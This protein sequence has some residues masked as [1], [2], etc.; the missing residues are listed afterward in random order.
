MLSMVIVSVSGI[1]A[2]LY[3]YSFDRYSLLYY[4]DSISHLVAARK[5]VDWANPSIYQIGTVW[6][7]LLH[8]FLIPFTL[9]DFLFTNG[10]AGTI[11]SLSALSIATLYMVKIVSRSQGSERIAILS[12]L[13]FSS[14]PSI[15]YMGVIAM[16]ESIFLAFF[17]SSVYYA[18]VWHSEYG[19]NSKS[20][21]TLSACLPLIVLAT[22]TRYEGWLLPVILSILVVSRIRSFKDRRGRI[23]LLLLALASF[24]GIFFWLLWNSLAFGDPLA[25][26]NTPLY[27]YLAQATSRPFREFLFL[28]PLSS[29]QTLISAMEV[30]YGAPLLVCSFIGLVSFVIRGNGFGRLILIMLLTLPTLATY[31]A[32]VLG[33]GEVFDQG[34]G[35]WFNSRFVVL[36]SGAITF[37]GISFLGLTKRRTLVIVLVLILASSAVFASVRQLGYPNTPM[38]MK[39]AYAGFTYRNETLSAIETAKALRENYEGGT[40]LM[41]TSSGDAHK[42]MLSSGI[43]LKNF[44]D[45]FSE[46]SWPIVEDSRIFNEWVIV[47][48]QPAGDAVQAVRFLQGK[49]TLLNEKY[50]IVG[51]N[52]F[53]VLM[54]L[55]KS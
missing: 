32:M 5:F 42:I 35:I 17:T 54:K 49:S 7:P 47:S 11:V 19:R 48:L 28:K 20:L 52:D 39:E 21:R 2:S 40:I 22:L 6:L 16:Q 9:N 13:I 34:G 15:V 31:A 14:N 33:V 24:G 36:A 29:A 51:H 18:Y 44:R 4:G 26:L 38:V 41:L 1:L 55:I 23:L 12:G 27:S 25:F 3:L 50:Q 8:F 46:D 53:F 10:F 45:L 43:Q 37:G 30:M